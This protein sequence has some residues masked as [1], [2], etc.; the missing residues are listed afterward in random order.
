MTLTDVAEQVGMPPSTAHRILATLQRHDFVEFDPVSQ[1]W[2]VGIE[3]F[4]T[5]NA[6]LGRTSLVEIS[7]KSLHDLMELT[8]ETANLGIAN[9]G[10]V[11]FISQVETDNPVRAFFRPGSRSHIHA[12]GIGKAMLAFYSS[13]EVER[14]TSISGLP[15]FT[16]NTL[17]S[18][19]ALA[20][21][22]ETS[23]ARGWALDNEERYAGMRCIASAIFNSYGEAIAGVSVSGPIIRFPDSSLETTGQLVR[24]TAELITSQTGG[25]VPAR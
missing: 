16:P 3:A 22:L 20:R 13:A 24:E 1:K 25:I 5:G 8:G 9:R 19:Q 10:D 6:Y 17:T 15:Q 14:I 12:S 18:L 7:R 21:D 2:G 11:V 23:R 4:R